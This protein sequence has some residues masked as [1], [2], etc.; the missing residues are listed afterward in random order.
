[1]V[2]VDSSIWIEAARRSGDIGT[3]VALE[4][5]LAEYE[6]ILCAPVKLEVLGGCRKEERSGM[7]AGFS[8]LPYLHVLDKDWTA[9]LQVGWRLRDHGI[10]APWNDILIATLALR[11]GCRV[12]ARDKHFEQM[13]SVLGISLYQPGYGGMY[14]PG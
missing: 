7:E 13:S 6:A 2:I 11:S 10:T 1:M 12:Y 4:C 3:K 5:L 9:A 14:N 8:C